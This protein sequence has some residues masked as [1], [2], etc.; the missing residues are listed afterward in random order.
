MQGRDRA[1]GW[2]E[3]EEEEY[4]RKEE[5]EVWRIIKRKEEKGK[6]RT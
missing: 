6:K 4:K 3:W 5:R 1:K 2:S